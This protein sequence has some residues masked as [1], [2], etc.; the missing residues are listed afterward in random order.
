LKQL[1]TGL[2]VPKQYVCISEEKFD[3]PLSVFLT[4]KKGDFFIEVT[5]T[6]NLLGYKPVVISLDVRALGKFEEEE[7]CLNFISGTFEINDVWHGFKTNKKCVARLIFKKVFIIILP[8]GFLLFESTYGSHSFINPFH[9]YINNFRE[10]F[11]KKIP[12]NVNLPGNL[13]DQVR[14]AYSVPR[15]IS[16]IT[17]GDSENMNMFPTDLH[18]P[19]GNNFYISSLRK[20]GKANE[21]VIKSGKL[22]L[23]SMPAENHEQV[24]ALGKNHMQHLSSS[25]S[26]S[27]SGTPSQVFNVPLPLNAL[28]YIEL[29]RTTSIDIGIHCIHIYE[30]INNKELK[31]GN[32]LAHIHQYYTQWRI[33]QGLT[34][35]MLNL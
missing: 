11:R 20:G 5:Y 3:R 17:L 19:L 30:K 1:L 15:N 27:I 18:G 35:E 13:Y 16:A 8:D 28:R 10:R 32:T 6:H 23:S 29:R 34:V 2:S 9:Q 12:G 26:F 22:V 25:K 7:I 24:Y 4:T 33:N 31:L 21:Q 14:I